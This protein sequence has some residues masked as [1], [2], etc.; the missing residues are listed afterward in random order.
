MR[1]D[2]LAHMDLGLCDCTQCVTTFAEQQLQEVTLGQASCKNRTIRR[3]EHWHHLQL[4][5]KQAHVT[6]AESLQLSPGLH[7]CPACGP[8]E[9]VQQAC[10]HWL[11][12]TPETQWTSRQA[13]CFLKRLNPY[14]HWAV[15]PASRS[16]QS[17]QSQSTGP[18]LQERDSS[19]LSVPA[20][21]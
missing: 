15:P 20:G 3:S 1:W 13:I 14:C 17:H 8:R 11:C 4:K 18:G 12:C 9:S 7:Y 2:E 21:T 6:E 10:E 16:K 19:Q 5:L